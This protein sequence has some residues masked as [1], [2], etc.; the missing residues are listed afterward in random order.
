MKKLF[1]LLILSFFSAQ[2]FAGSCPDGSDPVK[3]ISA[4]GTYFVYNCGGGNEQSSSSNGSW[5]DPGPL[6][7]LTIP[8]NWQLFKYKQTLREARKNFA[9]ISFPGF[10]EQYNKNTCLSVVKDWG[11]SMIIYNSN[12]K[13]LDAATGFGGEGGKSKDLQGCLDKFIYSTQD[14][15]G[16]PDYIKEILLHWAKTDAVFIPNGVKGENWG[17]YVYEAVQSWSSFG[18]YY[19]TFYDEFNYSDTERKIVDAYIKDKLL[20]LDTRNLTTSSHGTTCDPDNLKRTVEGQFSNKIDPNSC[21]SSV[22]KTT[23]AQLL[24]GL[25]LNDK[26][27]F[28]KGVE[29]TKYQLSFFDDTGIFT[30]WAIKGSA[31]YQYTSSVPVMLGGLTEIYASVGYDFMEHKL[32]NGLSVKELMDRQYELFLDPHILD[33][34]VKRYPFAYKGS[35]NSQYLQSTAEQIRNDTDMNLFAFVRNLPRYIDTYRADIGNSQEFDKK[36]SSQP[37]EVWEKVPWKS[38]GSFSPIDPYLVYVSDIKEP[39]SKTKV[40]SELSIFEVDGQTFSLALDKVDF[41]ETGSFELERSAEYLRDYQLHKAVIQ[42]R[43]KTKS[44]GTKQFKTLVYKYAGTQEQKLVIHVDYPTIKPLK[45]HKDSLEK[46]CGSKVMEWG[47]LSFISE[48][49]DIKSARNQQCIYDYYKEANDNEAFELF[50]AILGGT[51][52]ILDYLETKVDEPELKTETPKVVTSDDDP[53]VSKVIEVIH[54]DTFIVDIAEP[55]ELAGSNIKLII[56]D[57]N[58]PDSTKSCSKQMELGIEVKDIVTQKLA[59]ASS[60]KLKN[61]RKTSKAVIAQVIVDGKDLGEELIAKG[62]ASNEYGHWKAYFCSSL[63]AM[64]SGDSNWKYG[65]TVDVDKA[66]FWYERAIF[67]DPDRDQKL[68]TYDLSELY[69]MN[70]D[71]KKSIDY[72]KQSAELGYMKAEEA[73]GA[74]YMNGDGVSKNLAQAKKWLK[75]AYENG[76]DSAEDIC[77]CEF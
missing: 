77:G 56:R 14:S 66:I 76:S 20:N 6:D 8:D 75:K 73:L 2:S 53:T 33:S 19:A 51:D 52:S 28:K 62:Y 55:H 18:S 67:L 22:W 10:G 23:L 49:N 40:A 65:G 31:S 68:V 25:R 29:N 47:W 50:Q 11:Q 46:K 37:Q 61:F 24:V 15:T 9:L 64:A 1:L 44:N 58:T 70:G 39:E 27:L 48:T 17:N 7:E 5:N 35:S 41:S 12:K 16:T 59:D 26:A 38:L 30:T 45:Q 13:Q 4:D 74:A 32:R 43:L 72:L 3:S 42:G 69:K 71:T 57:A 60:I 34:Y 21:G 54:G 36:L 63:Q